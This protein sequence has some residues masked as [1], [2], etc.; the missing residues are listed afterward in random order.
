V[1][2]VSAGSVG[3]LP[4]SSAEITEGVTDCAKAVTPG[5]FDRK[6]LEDAGWKFGGKR[7]AVLGG[8]PTEQVYLGREGGNVI[9]VVQLTNKL[10]TSCLT[11]AKVANVD[12]LSEIRTG[13]SKNFRAMSFD[14]YDGD[15]QFKAFLR[16][17]SPKEVGNMMIGDHQRFAV[18]LVEGSPNPSIKILM[19]PKRFE[20]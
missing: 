11:I 20:K 13:I 18:T 9:N 14:A 16:K 19:T 8:L 3:D 6:I 7:Q 15:E 1:P 5:A 17:A 10:S 2:A 12:Q 4:A